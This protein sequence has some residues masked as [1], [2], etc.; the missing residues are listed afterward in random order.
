MEGSTTQMWSGI[1]PSTWPAWRPL[2]GELHCMSV[3]VLTEAYKDKE[4]N[5]TI[6]GDEDTGETVGDT[7]ASSQQRQ[8]HHCVWDVDGV[9]WVIE[10]NDVAMVD[11]IALMGF[12]VV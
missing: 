1:Y 11:W 7:G 5:L 9:T 4:S 12:K 8:P 6:S 2:P 10:I 3:Y